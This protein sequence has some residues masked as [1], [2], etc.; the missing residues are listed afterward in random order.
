MSAEAMMIARGFRRATE[1]AEK[2]GY[3][4]PTI[5]RW[6]KRGWVIH[7]R[8]GRELWISLASAA[9]ILGVEKIAAMWPEYNP[10][11][12]PENETPG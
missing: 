11:P 3:S 9:K 4:R 5:S 8:M 10:P 2:T 7:E 6:V 12:P 1:I